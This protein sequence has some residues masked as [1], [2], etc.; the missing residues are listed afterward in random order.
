MQGTGGA[1]KLRWG[2]KGK[3]TRGGARVI[4]YYGGLD[5]PVFLLA[6]F[7]KGERA[8]LTRAE[9]NE[10]REVLASLAVK[11]RKGVD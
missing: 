3:G 9:R 5:L 10:L 1:R 11:Y 8:N 2:A 6:I 7:A 4:T